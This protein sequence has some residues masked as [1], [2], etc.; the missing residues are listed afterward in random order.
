MISKAELEDEVRIRFGVDVY[1]VS[2][3]Q[4]RKQAATARVLDTI[5]LKHSKRMTEQEAVRIAL[6]GVPIW[7]F[8][9]RFA[10][11]ELAIWIFRRLNEQWE[12]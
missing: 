7:M 4:S 1:A 3:K 6:L 8:L 12:K 11:K 5:Y 9:L 2:G 10:L